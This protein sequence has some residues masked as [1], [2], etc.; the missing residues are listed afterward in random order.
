MN[1]TEFAK[2]ELVGALAAIA[3][4]C[5]TN[6]IADADDWQN[7]E[8]LDFSAS[9]NT[10]KVAPSEFVEVVA[11]KV[12][13]AISRLKSS[14]AIAQSADAIAYFGRSGFGCVAPKTPYLVR[15][16]YRNGG[17]GMFELTYNEFGLL[18]GHGELGSPSALKRTALIVCLDN[19]PLQVFTNT[20]GGI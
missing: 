17:T 7:P 10:Q 6:A 20:Y 13:V 15:A 3:V 12:E 2:L 1:L 18:V 8:S 19:Q 16:V 11:S 14:A 4:L 5:S 9:P